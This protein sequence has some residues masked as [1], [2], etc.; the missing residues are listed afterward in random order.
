MVAALLISFLAALR[1]GAAD[2]SWK[3]VIEFLSGTIDMSS[4]DEIILRELRMPRVLCAMISG[5]AFAVS[6]AVLQGVLRNVLASPEITGV[7]AGGG[8][9]GLAA[10]LFFAA[11]P[12]V[13]VLAV[14]AGALLTASAVYLLAWKNGVSPLRIILSGVAFSSLCGAICSTMMYI[15]SDKL[16]QVLAFSLGSFAMRSSEDLAAV[17][18]F[19]ASGFCL[20]F[21]M[22]KKM[23]ILQLGDDTAQTLGVPVEKSRALLLLSGVLLA[24]SGVSLAGLI[25]FAGLVI[26]HIVRLFFSVSDSRTLFLRSAVLGAVF[27]TFCDT[28]GK[29]IAAPIEIPAGVLTSLAGP[30]FFLW[31]LFKREA[32]HE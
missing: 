9:A 22:A 18:P 28:V 11:G 30:P 7:S 2:I 16:S 20:A 1:F 21:F 24:A 14:F 8:V 19:A 32:R 6:G 17:L 13:T 25:G 4:P 29:S 10:V 12:H 27:V 3:S 15:E 5:A 31:L 23:D 26:P